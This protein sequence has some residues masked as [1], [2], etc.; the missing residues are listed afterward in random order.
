LS[1]RD[2]Q[3][4][5]LARKLSH[6]STI[7]DRIY[8]LIEIGFG[9]R[10]LG[11]IIG[12]S[13]ESIRGWRDG[14]SEPKRRHSDALDD[15]RAVSLILLEGGLSGETIKQWFRSTPPTRLG[16]RQA[17]RPIDVIRSD[18]QAVTAAAVAELEEDYDVM[19]EILD[20]AKRPA[21]SPA[22]TETG[23]GTDAV[24]SAEAA[25]LNEILGPAKRKRIRTQQHAL[26]SSDSA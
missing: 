7:A 1:N 26:A 4:P 17:P 16:H 24:A 6:R 12:V 14:R 8:G 15:L 23:D 18:P 5:A 2:I 25:E 21:A 20:E 9:M 11:E 22:P 3:T 10:E 19:A 13:D